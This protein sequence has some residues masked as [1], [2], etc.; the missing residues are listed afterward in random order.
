MGILQHSTGV[1]TIVRVN[2]TNFYC[3]SDETAVDAN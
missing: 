1:V 2:L 3:V